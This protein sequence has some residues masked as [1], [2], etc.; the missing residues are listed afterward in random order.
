MTV[1][2]GTRWIL[3]TRVYGDDLYTPVTARTLF[4]SITSAVVGM[5]V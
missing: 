2:W 1:C 3:G 4:N 5:T